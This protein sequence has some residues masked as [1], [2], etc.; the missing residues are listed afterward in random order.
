MEYYK[1][2]SN[3]TYAIDS[4]VF[5][6]LLPA[7][8]VHITKA[9]ADAILAMPPV[10]TVAQQR[11]LLQPLSAWQVRKVLTQLNLRTQVENA[12]TASDQATK[13][14]WQYANE[15][16]R[17]NVLLNNM[18]TSLGLTAAQLDNMFTVGITL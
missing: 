10:L 5:A 13:D 18:A 7:G 12:I 4:K 2:S 6:N 3:Q 8:C 17:D 16:R 1:D 9:E 11:A 15:F 14:A